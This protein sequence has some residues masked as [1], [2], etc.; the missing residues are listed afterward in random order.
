MLEFGDKIIWN[1]NN[2]V[3]HKAIILPLQNVVYVLLGSKRL[4]T[5]FIAQMPT[6]LVFKANF[7]LALD[8]Q[9]FTT[10]SDIP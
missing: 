7:V 8:L 1:T 9:Q 10:S 3:S 4:S 6:S 2:N 5:I